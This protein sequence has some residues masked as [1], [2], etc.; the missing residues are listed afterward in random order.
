MKFGK[1]F[2]AC[3]LAASTFL[4]LGALQPLPVKAE[5][6]SAA[7]SGSYQED[8]EGLKF[9]QSAWNYD[10]TNN[11]FWQIGVRYCTAPASD[12]YET[13]GIYVPGQYMRGVKNSDGTYTCT[14][15][16]AGTL[17]GY[18][19]KTAPVIWPVDTPG[20]AAQ[21]A[22]TSYSYDS[23]SDYVKAG[24]VY[25]LAGM[26]GRQSMMGSSNTAALSYSCG[27][28][29]GVT[30][31]KA[32]IRFIRYNMNVL[33]GDT[34]NFYTYG[35]S[36]GGAQS[37]LA[38]ATGNSALYT[39]YLEAIGAAMTYANGTAVNDAVTGSMCWCPVTNLDIA[40]EAYEW[41]MGQYF[42]TDTRASSS[43]TSALSKDMAVNFVAY[44]NELGLKSEDGT[45]LVL[46]KS[47]TGIYNAGSYYDYMKKEVETSL[48]NFLS[49]N[50]FP[51]TYTPTQVQVGNT[52]TSGGAQAQAFAQANGGQGTQTAGMPQMTG[53]PS[54]A[55]GAG[56][57]AAPGALGAGSSSA[58][59]VVYQTP[60]DY[61]DSLNEDGKWVS[62]DAAAN[63]A[64]I[65]DMEAFV[66]NCKNPSKPVGA[67]DYL[68]KS[69]G[70]NNLFGNAEDTSAH[71]D[72]FENRLLV[73]N[74]SK[75]AK[76]SDW[77]ASY[78]TDFAADLASKDE[79][80]T[81]MAVRSNMYNPMYFLT[82]YYDG[83]K[84]SNVAKYWRIRTGIDQSDTALC[85]EEDLKLALEN[86]DGVKSV[87]FATVW[88]QP[89]T[90]A[91]RTG[92]STDNFIAWVNACAAK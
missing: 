13:L 36:G 71:F 14:V 51:Y 3:V 55:Q 28:P 81:A 43:F 38:G 1:K 64:T 58:E 6:G 41:N 65:T 90:T 27:A 89:H 75:Y 24:F 70:E 73:G 17:K 83:Y 66:V 59:S 74:A 87:D 85:T 76:Y 33:P 82:D 12:D 23:V 79:I 40:D 5:A 7:G 37:A 54:G 49:D 60:Q 16:N 92:N 46:S 67:F 91:E 57:G 32:A 77:K 44:I 20:Y 62:Y 4:S 22:P 86:Y 15:N 69:R 29:W 8:Y 9:D 35:M 11:V 63:T 72:A 80:G 47:D 10:Q 42:D 50:T 78:L 31:L 56:F 30:D 2:L 19:A 84:T 21:K 68:D 25:V 52:A 88:G 26:R 61:I 45:K 53:A 39:P 48:N 34:D 18:T